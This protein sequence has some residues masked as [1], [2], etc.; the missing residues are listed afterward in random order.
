MNSR[1]CDTVLRAKDG[2]PRMFER[3]TSGDRLLAGYGES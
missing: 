3:S 2:Q 1:P